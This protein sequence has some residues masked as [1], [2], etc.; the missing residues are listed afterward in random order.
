MNGIGESMMERMRMH[1]RDDVA[2]VEAAVP[3]CGDEN[4]VVV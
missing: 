3:E 1:N 4:H 2:N